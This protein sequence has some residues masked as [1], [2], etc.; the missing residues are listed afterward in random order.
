MSIANRIDL[1]EDQL[2]TATV[3]H[4]VTKTALQAAK[5]K[6]ERANE[7]VSELKAKIAY[8]RLESW[9]SNPDLDIL[10]DARESSVY[11]GA[12]V[13]LASH[14]KM[15]VFGQWGD[16]H[17]LC[18]SFGMSRSEAGAIERL[19]KGIRY[20]APAIKRVKG[21]WTRFAVHCHEEDCAWQLHFSPA[22]GDA[23]LVKLF[24]CV[25]REDLHFGT[26]EAALAHVE[27]HLWAS[28][29]IDAVI[30]VPAIELQ[31]G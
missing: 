19:A 31:P 10:L 5:R 25:E 3:A 29:D 9:G 12:T 22:R 18:L 2:R 30:D 17:Q 27:M 7:K 21:G 23:K 20:F 8:A 11:Y 13:Q 15:G 1:L 14:F 6:E 24:H 16:S 28:N 26:L 4:A